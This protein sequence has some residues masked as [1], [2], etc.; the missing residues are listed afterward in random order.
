MRSLSS[1]FEATL[2]WRRTER[3]NLEKKP[4][5]R[6][7]QEPCLG[8]TAKLAVDVGDR[9]FSSDQPAPHAL[10]M[11]ASLRSRPNLRSAANRRG[12]PQ[13]DPCTAADAADGL[14]FLTQYLHQR[15]PE[16]LVA[17]RCL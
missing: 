5:M 10:G 1:C 16:S 8:D 14:Q 9:S 12:V 11:S 15:A 3:A 17:T 13:P 6:L 7:S 2:M 4:S